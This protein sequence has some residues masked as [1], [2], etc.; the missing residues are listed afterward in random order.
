[1]KRTKTKRQ[2]LTKK[3]WAEEWLAF[4]DGRDRVLRHIINMVQGI[5]EENTKQRN[6]VVKQMRA[7][8]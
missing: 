4:Y 6:Q 2:V 3:K 5:L 1:M 8:K 7:K